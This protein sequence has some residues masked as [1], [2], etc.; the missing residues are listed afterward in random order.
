MIRQQESTISSDNTI[1]DTLKNELGNYSLNESHVNNRKSFSIHNTKCYKT[2]EYKFKEH[3][4]NFK[5]IQSNV[6]SNNSNKEVST[7]TCWIT[8]SNTNN[9][10]NKH[11]FN[12]ETFT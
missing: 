2:L 9:K 8:D 1:I 10:N 3:E 5:A 7:Y 4:K 12:Y 6:L 11:S